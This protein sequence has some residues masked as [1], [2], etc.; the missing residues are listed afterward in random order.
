MVR[1][2]P[3]F[4]EEMQANV[5]AYLSG[6][7]GE[8][9]R[10]DESVKS[11]AASI[12]DGKKWRLTRDAYLGFIAWMADAATKESSSR[13]RNRSQADLA[14]ALVAT[15]VAPHGSV[16][17]LETRMEAMAKVGATRRALRRQVA[18]VKQRPLAKRLIEIRNRH[19]QRAVLIAAASSPR[20]DRF[21]G[22]DLNF[23]IKILDNAKK[24]L[25]ADA[26]VGWADGGIGDP[27]LSPSR[28]GYRGAGLTVR[29][30]WR[31]RVVAQGLTYVDG[32][33]VLDALP[34]IV[35]A[36][37]AALTRVRLAEWRAWY[38][39]N[40]PREFAK[41]TRGDDRDRSPDITA[42]L[43]VVDVDVQRD[44]PTA[45]WRVCAAPNRKVDE[46]DRY[47]R[48]R[49][50]EVWSPSSGDPDAD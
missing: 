46:D 28:S 5:I 41:R 21:V 29:P 40:Q 18:A 38:D 17:I 6:G 30:D 12:R 47:T 25:P 39:R 32:D 22:A 11:I 23:V 44:S 8:G 49:K 14:R 3:T 37:G 50:Y 9:V 15:R 36:S 10:D 20:V 4:H 45:P 13:R 24:P 31:E 19:V 7:S 27:I 2:K 33:L 16:R 42:L 34:V 48:E 43:S 26:L 1:F 35:Q